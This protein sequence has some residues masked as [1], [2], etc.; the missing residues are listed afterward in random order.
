MYTNFRAL[1]YTKFRARVYKL[2]LCRIQSFGLMYTKFRSRFL[3][4]HSFTLDKGRGLL[5]A[6]NLLYRD[7]ACK[8][9][10]F[11]QKKEGRKARRL[12]LVPIKRRISKIWYENGALFASAVRRFLRCSPLRPCTLPCQTNDNIQNGK[13]K[14]PPPTKKGGGLFL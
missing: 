10:A 11:G 4:G 3:C 1:M 7:I 9:G 13:T 5:S 14:G 2:S 8:A 12:Y 6:S